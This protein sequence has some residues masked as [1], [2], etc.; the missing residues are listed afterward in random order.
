MKKRLISFPIPNDLYEKL[1]E[2]I[3]KGFDDLKTSFNVLDTIQPDDVKTYFDVFGSLSM[4]YDLDTQD[5]ILLTTCIFQK[6]DFF[7]TNDSKLA[8]NPIR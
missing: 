4:L 7:I 2:E 3:L 1:Y 6:S 8:K 5:A